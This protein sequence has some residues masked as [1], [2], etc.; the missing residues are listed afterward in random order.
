[1]GL[2]HRDIK[3]ANVYACRMGLDY[4]FAK[5]LDFGL[6]KH[7]DRSEAPTS[8]TVAAIPM[9]TPGYLAPEVILGEAADCRVDVYAVGC[10][11]YFLLTGKMVFT[12]SNSMKILMQHLQDDPIPPSRCSAQHIPAAV[13]DFVRACLEKDPRRRPE[14]GEALLQ[15]ACDCRTDDEWDPRA[16]KLWWQTHLPQH[17]RPYSDNPTVR[18]QLE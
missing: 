15:M 12:A 5:V 14:N 11:A 9:G 16:A 6:V 1:M 17:A 8:L 18:G 2:V 13:D 4:D 7:Q 10:V 3:P